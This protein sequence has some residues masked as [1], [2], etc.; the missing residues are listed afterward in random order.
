MKKKKNH[1]T[2]RRAKALDRHIL[3]I[4]GCGEREKILF[5]S[6]IFCT[7]E[8]SRIYI[9]F[10][11]CWIIIRYVRDVAKF[12]GRC[13]TFMIDWRNYISHVNRKTDPCKSLKSIHMT[14]LRHV[15]DRPY[16]KYVF[17]NFAFQWSR[18]DHGNC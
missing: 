7:R 6:S 18:N 13:D 11:F 15:C 14:V 5:F 12:F 3:R 1:D 8:I 2:D 17:N 10:T 4:S 16:A 9:W